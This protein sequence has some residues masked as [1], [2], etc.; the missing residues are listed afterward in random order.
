MSWTFHYR[1]SDT[2][3]VYIYISG[4][5]G[6]KWVWPKNVDLC[7]Y[8]FLL[9][10]NYLFKSIKLIDYIFKVPNILQ[11]LMDSVQI[12]PMS[13]YSTPSFSNSVYYDP[14]SHG[15]QTHDYIESRCCADPRGDNSQT[16]LVSMDT[17]EAAFLPASDNVFSSTKAEIF[18]Y[19]KLLDNWNLIL[20][21]KRI[22]NGTA[23]KLISRD[24]WEITNS[25]F[26]TNCL[27]FIVKI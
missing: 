8:T 9:Y 25:L 21:W 15:N 27:L 14:Q 17:I 5:F 3:C 1:R 22:D 10:I 18:S 19:M 26:K 23:E 16:S 24:S 7:W 20:K 4:K 11:S 13:N 2:W 12:K 6:L